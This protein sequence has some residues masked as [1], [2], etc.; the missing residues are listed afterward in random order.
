VGSHRCAIRDIRSQVI[1]WRWLRRL[2]VRI[3]CL[4]TALRN[5][6]SALIFPG[7]AK[8][9]KCPERTLASQRP[10]T[11]I[12]RWARLRISIFNPRSLALIRFLLVTLRTLN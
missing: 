11:G 8:Y 10:W 9:R 6:P 3:H 7:T 4:M 5:E 1:R 2:S 12:G